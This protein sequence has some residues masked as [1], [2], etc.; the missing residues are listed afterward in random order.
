MM[1]TILQRGSFQT[2]EKA[3]NRRYDPVAKMIRREDNGGT[4]GCSCYF[5]VAMLRFLCKTKM[6]FYIFCLGVI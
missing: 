3:E 6:Y 4:R 1:W 5:F 2:M